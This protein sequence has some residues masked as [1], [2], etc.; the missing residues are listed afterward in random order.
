MRLTRLFAPLVALTLSLPLA[1]CLD[2]SE[3]TTPITLSTVETTTFASSLGIDLTATGWTRTA[4]GL[5]YRTLSAPT[6]TPA[7]VTSG[8]HVTVRYTGW[9]STGT[10]FQSST[11]DFDLG[12]GQVIPGW[13]EGILGMRVGERRRLLIPPALGYGAGGSGPIPGNAVLVF[14]VE[15]VSA[16]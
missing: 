12:R 5:Y 1:A 11:I 14:D 10:Q 8:K 3:T 4:S 6:G 16:T 2:T 9:L 15:V 7:T 13:D